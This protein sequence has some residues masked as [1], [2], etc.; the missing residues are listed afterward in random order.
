MGIDPITAGIIMGGMGLFS[1]VVAG[2]RQASPAAPAAPEQTAIEDPAVKK[3]QGEKEKRQQ[4]LRSNAGERS[5]A[6]TP[7]ANDN[8]TVTSKSLL[9]L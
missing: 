1:S 9:G 6:F 5:T 8:E 3:K 2:G 4:L 7:L